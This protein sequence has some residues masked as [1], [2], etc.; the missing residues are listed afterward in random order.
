M[1]CERGVARWHVQGVGMVE[2]HFNGLSWVSAAHFVSLGC[3]ESL[4]CTWASSLPTVGPR[5]QL[6]VLY[7]FNRF[8]C[9][10]EQSPCS[11]CN[12]S[13]VTVSHTP[14]GQYFVG[15]VY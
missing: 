9:H 12:V 11:V 6:K 10:L 4:Q 14:S 1:A 15:K 5:S 8:K 3:I 2:G 7:H 13:H